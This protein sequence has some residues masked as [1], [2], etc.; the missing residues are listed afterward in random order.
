MRWIA[1]GSPPN[2]ECCVMNKCAGN[3]TEFQAEL[4][5]STSSALI[6]FFTEAS[7][8]SYTIFMFYFLLLLLH[9][10]DPRTEQSVPPIS[11]FFLCNRPNSVYSLSSCFLAGNGKAEL[12]PTTFFSLLLFSV[13]LSF[14]LS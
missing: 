6:N 11:K 2:K 10:C 8:M 13:F 7:N 3:R 5:F 9:L 14:L 12:K 1:L 4:L